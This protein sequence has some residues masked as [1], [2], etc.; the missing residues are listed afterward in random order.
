MLYGTTESLGT[1]HD[2]EHDLNR[3]YNID[4]HRVHAHAHMVYTMLQD[5]LILYF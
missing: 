4:K 2:I 1:T 5:F 3:S